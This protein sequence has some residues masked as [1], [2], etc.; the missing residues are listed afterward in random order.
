L[1]AKLA[2]NSAFSLYNLAA[3]LLENKQSEE[4]RSV[5]REALT[6]EPTGW[7]ADFAQGMFALEERKWTEAIAFFRKSIGPNPRGG[8]SHVWL[9]YALHMQGRQNEAR[10]EFRA[11]L[12]C[13]LRPDLVDYTNQM[14]A[15]INEEIGTD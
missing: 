9:A 4:A 12:R 6:L 13:S 15:M 1:A 10:D 11:G 8:E 2:P 5:L 7:R 3:E 14:I